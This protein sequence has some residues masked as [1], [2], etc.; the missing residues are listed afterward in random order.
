MLDLQSH[1]AQSACR[2]KRIV[3]CEKQTGRIG[4]LLPLQQIPCGCIMS[5][6]CCST[7]NSA[8]WMLGR[9]ESSATSGAAPRP[10]V[11]SSRGMAQTALRFGGSTNS[12]LGC[13]KAVL[14]FVQTRCSALRYTPSMHCRKR[15]LASKSCAD[16]ITDEFFGGLWRT[17]S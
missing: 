10:N 11:N 17:T 6:T 7:G 9:E 1:Q 15:C 3:A 16:L 12:D 5:Q 4:A 2:L 8:I 14:T 13:C